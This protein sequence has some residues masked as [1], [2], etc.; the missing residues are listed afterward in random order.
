MV[1]NNFSVAIKHTFTLDLYVTF[2]FAFCLCVSMQ[3][4]SEP[5]VNE[6]SLHKA[7]I[8]SSFVNKVTLRRGHLFL[9]LNHV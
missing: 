7:T 9:C 8:N 3:V 1:K 4:F 2:L 5:C 6:K